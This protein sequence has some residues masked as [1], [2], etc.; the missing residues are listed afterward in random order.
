MHRLAVGAPFANL[1][2]ARPELA[3]L[4]VARPVGPCRA[5][6]GL[7]C[8]DVAALL[9]VEEHAVSLHKV[10]NHAMRQLFGKSRA[11]LLERETQMLG[12]LLS[13]LRGH[14]DVGVPAVLPAAVSA[15]LAFKIH[16]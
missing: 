8:M 9:L 5:L 13:I 12:Y 10:Q 2:D 14:V 16:G 1:E 15:L 4:D 3:I 6:P 7:S 11:E